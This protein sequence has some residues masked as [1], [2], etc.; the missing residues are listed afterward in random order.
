[1]DLGV[2]VDE[3]AE[4]LREPFAQAGCT[5]R[6]E[7]KGALIGRW[8]RGRL[9]QVVTNL[10]SNAMK[11]GGGGAVDVTIEGRATT[12]ILVVRDYGPGV[13]EADRERI[14]ARFEHA[15]ARGEGG[16]GLGLG[17]YIAREIIVAH[18]GRIELTTP[19]GGGAAF[20][21]ELPH[22]SVG[23]RATAPDSTRGSTLVPRG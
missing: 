5:L 2:L 11:Y 23:A 22:P 1:M 7:R 10:L 12:A 13:P 14:F 6:V 9:A 19:P 3:V 18:G 8:D 4:T 21:I 15:T 16:R 20:E 17:L